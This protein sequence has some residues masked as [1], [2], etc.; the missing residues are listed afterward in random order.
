MRYPLTPLEFMQYE[1]EKRRTGM[2]FWNT[3]MGHDLARRLTST[4]PNLNKLEKVDDLITSIDA[5]TQ[6]TNKQN[7]LL[8]RLLEEKKEK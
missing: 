6:A 8:E 4:L 3:A 5:L 2:D 7:E 1:K